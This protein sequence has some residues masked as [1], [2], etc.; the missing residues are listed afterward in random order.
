MVISCLRCLP[1]SWRLLAGD[2]VGN[3]TSLGGESRMSSRE[4]D[5]GRLAIGVFDCTHIGLV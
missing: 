3:T 5:T 2:D 4:S 1:P